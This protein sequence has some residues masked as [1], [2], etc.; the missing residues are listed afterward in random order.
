[1]H[2]RSIGS[3]GSEQDPSN[4]LYMDEDLESFVK[5]LDSKPSLRLGATNEKSASR[6]Y[7]E[8]LREFKQLQKSNELFSERE[9]EEVGT[10]AGQ[11]DP[12]ARKARL[13]PLPLTRGAQLSLQTEGQAPPLPTHIRHLSNL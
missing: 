10:N 7:G 1:M 12:F 9:A 5:M 2:A 13:C 8:S 4:S 11:K 6:I 3:V